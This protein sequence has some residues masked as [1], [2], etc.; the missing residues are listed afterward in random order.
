[1]YKTFEQFKK[2]TAKTHSVLVNSGAK[3]KLSAY[4]EEIAKSLGFSDVNSLKS[5]LENP[6]IKTYV[7]VCMFGGIIEEL[8]TFKCDESGSEAMKK[9]FK[10]KVS[11]DMKLDEAD[12]IDEMDQIIYNEAIENLFYE[13]GKLLIDC[14]LKV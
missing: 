2:S 8:H 4:R 1:M 9:M 3:I 10:D 12:N 11:D 5:E 14:Y 13:S 7:L 6:N